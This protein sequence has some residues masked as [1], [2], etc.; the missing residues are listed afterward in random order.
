MN[1]LFPLLMMFLAWSLDTTD[2]QIQ[3]YILTTF[4]VVHIAV[5]AMLAFM[6]Y[7][8]WFGKQKEG[9]VVVPVDPQDKKNTETISFRVYDARKLREL[10]VSKILI[11][12][13]VIMFIYSRWGTILPLMFQCLNNPTQVYASEL[14]KIHVLGKAASYELG[15]P[16]PEPNP[17]PAWLQK[18]AGGSAEADDG[19][20]KK[21]KK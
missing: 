6:F 8:I 2:P 20:G 9:T 18:F 5:F 1:P 10:T 13:G 3:K 21:K 7:R 15:R 19:K 17:M 14:F 4:V 12:L 11:P 16:W